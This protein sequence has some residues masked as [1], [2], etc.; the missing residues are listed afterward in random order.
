MIPKTSTCE[1]YTSGH[2]KKVAADIVCDNAVHRCKFTAYL[3][4]KLRFKLGLVTAMPLAHS[5]DARIWVRFTCGQASEDK[6]L[7]RLVY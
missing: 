6:T 7:S 4:V 3:M 5:P 1:V 2:F